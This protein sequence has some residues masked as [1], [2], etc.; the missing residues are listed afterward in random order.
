MPFKP[1]NFANIE[2]QG[3]P[4]LRD[5]ISNLATGY[6]AGQLPQQLARQAEQEKLA[7]AMKQLLLQ[8]QPQ[9]FGEESQGRQLENALNRYKVQQEPQKFQEESLGRQLEN[10]FNKY[11]V[12]QEPQKFR[13]EM[14]TASMARALEQAHIN[15]INE[16]TKLPF[17]G[18]LPA[19]DVGQALYTN[20]IKSKY[21]E[22]SQE[23][24]M[25]KESYE[26]NLEHNRATSDRQ[27]QLISSG[28]FRSLPSSEKERVVSYA[29][30][31]GYTPDSAAKELSTGKTLQDLADQKG[32]NLSDVNPN[33]ALTT[34]VITA[35][36]NRTAFVKE[37]QNLESK[38][39]EPLSK[40]F[41]RY[42]QYSIPQI[43]SA[44]SNKN[45]DEQG[46]ILAARAMQPE[47][48]AF[49]IKAAAPNAQVGIQAI[50]ELQDKA[51]GNLKIIEATVSPETYRAMQGY[52]SQWT[53]DAVNVFNE[54]LHEQSKLGENFKSNT[55]EINK[56][57]TKRFNRETGKFEVI[58]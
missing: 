55:T 30:G 26:A 29:V 3:N 14:S 9:K 49:R 56:K 17:G 13:S 2:P 7:N 5:F 10:S 42:A 27:R 23:Y 54:S 20:M 47:L 44:I 25:A 12:Q 48:A 32:I 53:G 34:P 31:M 15:Q 40:T 37:I 11:K 19:G 18:K 43:V 28:M 46:K 4:S 33:Y 57:A 45:P 22:N 36:T 52:I 38:I 50:D 41:P 1:I 16:E 21:G 24:R 8:E 58:K 6:K 51:L 35:M 39:I